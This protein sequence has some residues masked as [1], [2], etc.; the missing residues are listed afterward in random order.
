ML[1]LQSIPFSSKSGWVTESIPMYK[2]QAQ[3]LLKAR[4]VH[5]QGKNRRRYRLIKAE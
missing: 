4:Q 3:A 5:N 1:I 2:K